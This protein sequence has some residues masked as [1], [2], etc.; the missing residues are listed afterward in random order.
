[1]AHGQEAGAGGATK[2]MDYYI[3]MTPF[4]EGGYE[5]RHKML[6]AVLGVRDSVT[7]AATAPFYAY[8]DPAG[9]I[10]EDDKV[11]P[12]Y[13]WINDDGVGIILGNPPVQG[14]KGAISGVTQNS[15]AEIKYKEIMDRVHERAKA[16]AEIMIA[17]ENKEAAETAAKKEKSKHKKSDIRKLLAAYATQPVQG[18][19]MTQQDFENYRTALEKAVRKELDEGRRHKEET[20]D[21]RSTGRGMTDCPYLVDRLAGENK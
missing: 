3:D 7:H 1:M 16:R 9:K 11:W 10:Q 21:G 17:L 12:W 18:G 15:L 4:M 13:D 8:Y 6:N 5:N 2:D 14:A 19:Y 20:A